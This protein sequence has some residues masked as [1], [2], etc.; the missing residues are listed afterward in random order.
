[1]DTNEDLNGGTEY[2]IARNVSTG[3][4]GAKGQRKAS[5]WEDWRGLDTP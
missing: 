1:M 5:P 4:F 2:R 3:F